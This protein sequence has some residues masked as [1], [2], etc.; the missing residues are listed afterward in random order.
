MTIVSQLITDAR[1]R[2]GAFRV[3]QLEVAPELLDQVMDHCLMLGGEVGIDYCIVEG[4]EVRELTTTDP[5][6]RVRLADD[7]HF[8][9]LVPLAED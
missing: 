8:H 5:T 1:S 4:I 2:F 9:P 3:R 6:P 7:D